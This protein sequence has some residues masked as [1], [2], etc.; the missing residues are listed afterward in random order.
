M[1]VTKIL[2]G[3]TWNHSRGF[4]PVVAAAQR[5]SEMYTDVE[6]VWEKRSLQEFADV[7]IHMLAE[8]YDLLVIDH[9]WAGFATDSKAVIPLEQ[10]L[11]VEFL[12]DQAMN[13]VGASHMSYN[14]GGFQSA[15][16]IDAA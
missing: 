5:Y 9:P 1:A 15:L 8:K 10:H 16:A 6:I 4:V 2:R 7:P 14:F 11:P 12:E 3:I 13:S